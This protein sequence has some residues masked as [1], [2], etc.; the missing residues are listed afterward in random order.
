M[1][2]LSERID[3]LRGAGL[4]DGSGARD[5]E[6]IADTLVA[7]CAVSRDDARLAALVTHVAAAIDRARRG[8]S[9]PPLSSDLVD[10]VRASALYPSIRHIGGEIFSSMENELPSDERDFVIVHIG[11]LLTSVRAKT[12]R[13]EVS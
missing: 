5:L 6:R 10:E 9:V 3:I 13:G 12:E 7:E 8:E 1:D 2:A 11:G 4:I